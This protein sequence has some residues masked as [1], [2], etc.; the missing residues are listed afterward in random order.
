MTESTCKAAEAEISSSRNAATARQF[1]LDGKDIEVME[2]PG[3][4]TVAP[5]LQRLDDTEGVV[6]ELRSGQLCVEASGPL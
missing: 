3:I 6:E 1:R 2:A 5:A 4:P